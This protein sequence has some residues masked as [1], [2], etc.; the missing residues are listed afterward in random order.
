M[1]FLRAL[2]EVPGKKGRITYIDTNSIHNQHKKVRMY[3]YFVHRFHTLSVIRHLKAYQMR[4]H[5]LI[6]VS[7]GV[8][9]VTKMKNSRMRLI[10]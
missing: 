7:L 4:V 2:Q 1:G 5:V 8:L 9:K 3:G 6:S 10:K